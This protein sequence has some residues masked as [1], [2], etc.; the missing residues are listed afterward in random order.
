M[1]AAQTKAASARKHRGIQIGS[2]S[3]VTQDQTDFVWVTVA[4]NRTD[5]TYVGDLWI[6]QQERE[7][8]DDKNMVLP[9]RSWRQLSTFGR[10]SWIVEEF[11][12]SEDDIS[13]ERE[14]MS[15]ACQKV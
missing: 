5:L 2:T 12:K 13:L 7:Y 10:R 9:E 8:K 1:L 4:C 15:A 11:E 6:L 14:D 3:L